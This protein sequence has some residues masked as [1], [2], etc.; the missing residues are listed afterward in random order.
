MLIKAF[1]IQSLMKEST[2]VKI[3][4]IVSMIG[5]MLLLILS[6]VLEPRLIKIKDTISLDTYSKVRIYGKITNIKST[7]G[8]LIM[9]ITDNTGKI[10]A[11]LDD[12]RFDLKVNDSIIV[13]GKILEYNDNLEI[14]TDKIYKN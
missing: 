7:K 10:N 9:T 14:Q 13:I 4:I 12:Q 1:Y 3:S 11:I 8:L 6:N 2:L 5:I